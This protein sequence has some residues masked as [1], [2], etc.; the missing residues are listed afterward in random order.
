MKGKEIIFFSGKQNPFECMCMH[1]LSD[2]YISAVNW[3]VT[4][5]TGV[6]W[7][8]E[9]KHC[10]CITDMHIKC[11][12]YFMEYAHNIFRMWLAPALTSCF[13]AITLSLLAARH[14]GI[15]TGSMV[16][17]IIHEWRRVAWNVQVSSMEIQN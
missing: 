16:L 9:L 12:G 7:V 3:D 11:E 13:M 4:K 15:I 1:E 6:K 5:C 14:G 2:K 8:D 10:L 17:F